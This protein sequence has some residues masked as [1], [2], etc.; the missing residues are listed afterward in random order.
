M[1]KKNLKGRRGAVSA[2][3]LAL[4]L[5]SSVVAMA[6]A[7]G[8]TLGGLSRDGSVYVE[9]SNTSVPTRSAGPVDGASVRL[10]S[11]I[12]GGVTEIPIPST[13]GDASG[14]LSA[15]G[16][17]VFGSYYD[18]E[19]GLYHVY[20][21]TAEG[22]FV[23]LDSLIYAQAVGISDNGVIAGYFYD[24]QG[25]TASIWRDGERMDVSSDSDILDSKAYGISRD[26]STVV[27]YLQR[28]DYS[29]HAMV[30][31][32]EGNQVLDI[33][34]QSYIQS[35]ATNVSNDGSVVAGYGDDANLV[36]VFRWTSAGGMQ[37]IGSLVDDGNISLAAMSDDG[38]VLV[39]EGT[40]S[41][42]E[43][44]AYRY[45]ASAAAGSRLTDLGVLAGDVSSSASD[46]SANGAYVVGS[47]TNADDVSHGFR[48]SQE[49]GML[50]IEQ[51]LADAGV[52][53]DYAT[54]SAQFISDDGK[55]VIGMTDDDAVYIARS[56]GIITPGG[57]V[58]PGGVIT[59]GGIIK[60]EE[61]FPTVVQVG[62][63]T[64]QN[65]ISSA[66]TI[67]FGAQ[68]NPMRN[69]L[70]VGER[71]A[72]G[73]VDGGYD[74]GDIS[75]GG[76]ALGEFGIGYGIADGIT[77]RLSAGG[78][79]TK[80]D[81]DSG[82]WVKQ[83]GYYL[84]PEV[85]ANVASNLYVTVGGYFSRTGIDTSRGY[86][87]GSTQDYSNGSTDADTWGGKIRF[88]W[89]NAVNVA[90]T[91]I[92][93]YAGLSYAR[94][95]VDA[96]AEN[97]GS[98]PVSYDE[99]SDHSTIARIGADFVRPM[100]DT[101]RLLAKTEVSYQFE[102]HTAATS[103]T[104]TGVTNFNI[105]GQDLKQLWVRG[106]IGTEI[107]VAGGTASFMVNATTQGQDPTVWLRSNYTVKF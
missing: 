45:V 55:V 101:V 96:Y 95:T 90:N 7:G 35:V 42:D 88:D 37:D 59:S 67:M 27:G 25:Y 104:L 38:N 21:W 82:G 87:N 75:K 89:L 100:S 83:K 70:G 13:A 69:L 15:D 8:Y 23:R 43:S 22:G 79:Y 33:D 28:S 47:S 6:D 32:L 4:S 17:A 53:A 3:A 71:S 78:S 40:A 2:L 103:G 77:A 97:G 16:K 93:P 98:F 41:S 68:G 64:L 102:S 99:T 61:F 48:W 46:V 105:E 30:W 5:G 24:S 31:N 9:F 86:L 20:S 106:G 92:T 73:T 107:D 49:T 74:D 56:G 34:P 80:Q 62:S 11:T 26:G 39:G 29:T 85:S 91:D 57:V 63:S 72:W 1:L 66:N 84:S 51:W 58:T 10:V 60:E 54:A 12:S 36:R 18:E 44:H 76:L 19:D 50:S 94:T 81:L 52:T 14:R 65:S